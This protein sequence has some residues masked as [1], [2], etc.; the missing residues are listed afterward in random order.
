MENRIVALDAELKNNISQNKSGA[1]RHKSLHPNKSVLGWSVQKS[2]DGYFR[3][4]R[5]VNN[6]VHYIFVM[7]ATT[8]S[9]KEE[10]IANRLE[11]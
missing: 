10:T 3:C 11:L 2:K 8:N 9:H 1:V 5:K 6:R 7:R 4:Y